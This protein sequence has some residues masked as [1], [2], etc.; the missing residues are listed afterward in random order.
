M[1]ELRLIKIINLWQMEVQIFNA[2]QKIKGTNM[3]YDD[4]ENKISYNIMSCSIFLKLFLFKL[5]DL[6]KF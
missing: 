1:T 2:H 4:S 6:Y 5:Q 3:K